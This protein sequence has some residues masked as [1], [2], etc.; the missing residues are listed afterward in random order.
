M[1][2]YI[3]NKDNNIAN[4]YTVA[5]YLACRETLMYSIVGSYDKIIV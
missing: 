5:T 1:V 2:Q 4:T 3:R